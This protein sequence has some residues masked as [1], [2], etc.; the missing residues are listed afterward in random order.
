M[1]LNPAGG[2]DVS[3]AS[4]VFCEVEVSAAGRSL[5]QSSPNESNVSEC[6]L[7]TSTTRISRPTMRQ[8]IW[9]TGIRL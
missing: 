3:F 4:V 8:S 5:I 6:D 9:I 1:G 7:E 2:K